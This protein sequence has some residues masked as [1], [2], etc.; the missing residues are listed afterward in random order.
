M[1]GPEYRCTLGHARPGSDRAF[2]VPY[3]DLH[4]WLRCDEGL[5][6]VASLQCGC[7][8]TDTYGDTWERLT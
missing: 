5:E 2:V 8:H 7:T 1:S 6:E 3:T 4:F